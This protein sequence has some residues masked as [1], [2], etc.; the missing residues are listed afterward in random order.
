[1]NSKIQLNRNLVQMN[2]LTT[3]TYYKNR[4]QMNKTERFR[5]KYNMGLA[6]IIENQRYSSMRTNFDK[7]SYDK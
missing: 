2:P 6:Q 4:C 5:W 1:M 7:G 3:E